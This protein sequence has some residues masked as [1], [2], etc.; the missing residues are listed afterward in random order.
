MYTRGRGRPRNNWMT[1]VNKWTNKPTCEL[2]RKVDDQEGWRICFV[3][4]SE[5]NPHTI[6]ESWDSK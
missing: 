1:I 3:K 2:L 5:M 6:Q 4:A